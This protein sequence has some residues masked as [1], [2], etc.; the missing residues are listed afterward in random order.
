MDTI[1]KV[2][3]VN[4]SRFV[5]IPKEFIENVHSKYMAVRMDDLGRIIYV[6]V[7]EGEHL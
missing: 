1:V 7:M 2:R 6:P 4:R 5:A 3:T